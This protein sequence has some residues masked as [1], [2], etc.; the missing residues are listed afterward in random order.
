MKIVF[1]G[2]PEFAVYSLEKIYNSSHEVLAVVTAPDTE[3]GRGLKVSYSAV[4]Q[5]AIERGINIL[6][7]ENLKDEALIND[8]R[9]LNADI[10]VVVAFRILPE[11]VYSIPQYGSFN[12]HASV[13]PKYRGA[14]P[15]QWALINGETE[16]GVTTFKI[17]KKVDTGNIYLQRLI[18]ID[19]VDDFGSLHD[20]LALIGR[21][22][23]L[24]T[25]NLI[26]SGNFNLLPQDN[27]LASPAP[28]ITKEICQIDWEKPATDIHNLIRGLSPHP[29][30]FFD[31]NGKVFKVFKSEIHSGK[32][33]KP[34]EVFYS[35]SEFIVGCQ[36]SSLKITELQQEGKKK[37][38]IEEFL[39]GFRN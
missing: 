22:A 12:L 25:I 23:V 9:L 38:K 29:A 1:F 20:K 35:Q 6:Q 3:K 15:I 11:E 16:T 4:K 27:S 5:F 26:E 21:E 14:A 37:L 39:R 34:G 7:P 2:T 10:F 33:L 13:L 32:A 17:E 18:K 31:Y 8:L 28:K 19:K 36:Q 30:A 24:E